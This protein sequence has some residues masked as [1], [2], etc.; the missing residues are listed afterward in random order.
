[1]TDEQFLYWLKGF[2]ENFRTTDFSI[3]SKLDIIRNQLNSTLIK[4]K[5]NEDS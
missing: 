1:M 4:D 5:E 3:N 2:L